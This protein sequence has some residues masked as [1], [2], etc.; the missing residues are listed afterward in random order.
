MNLRFTMVT[1]K[2]SRSLTKTSNDDQS[3]FLKYELNFDIELSIHILQPGIT[4]RLKMLS[5]FRKIIKMY[6]VVCIAMTLS[7]KT[8]LIKL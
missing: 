4:P 8:F 5:L 7:I 2:V 6:C 1:L 3:V